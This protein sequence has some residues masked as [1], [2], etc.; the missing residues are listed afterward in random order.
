MD[1]YMGL[2]LIGY[3][4][5][6]EVTVIGDSKLIIKGVRQHF[7]HSQHNLARSIHKILK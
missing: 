4:Q 6:K 7:F 3:E 2:K 1:L 5:Y